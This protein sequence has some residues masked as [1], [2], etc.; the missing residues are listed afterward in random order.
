MP[1]GSKKLISVE[2]VANGNTGWIVSREYLA[3]LTIPTDPEQVVTEESDLTALLTMVRKIHNNLA[4]EIDD[5]KTKIRFKIGKC[6]VQVMK[7]VGFNP[8][9]PKTW[10]YAGT[11]KSSLG[12]KWKD[13]YAPKGYNVMVV[14]GAVTKYLVSEDFEDKPEEYALHLEKELQALVLKDK[15]FTGL[16]LNSIKHSEGNKSGGSRF[17]LYM[18]IRLDRARDDLSDLDQVCKQISILKAQL[19]KLK[20]RKEELMLR[21]EDDDEE[22]EEEKPQNQQKKKKFKKT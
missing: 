14:I 15:G 10:K 9:Q 5:D 12:S 22:P 8:L 21:L 1:R 6:G 18:A 3:D 7:G 16:C 4:G 17:L 20:Q 19:K 2:G 11:A 13:D